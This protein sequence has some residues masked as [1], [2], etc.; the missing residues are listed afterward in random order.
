M[1]PIKAENRPLTLA[2]KLLQLII[3]LTATVT[4]GYIFYF[5]SQFISDKIWGTSIVNIG[6]SEALTNDELWAYRLSQLFYQLGTFLVSPLFF[7]FIIKKKPLVF[8]GL[9]KAFDTKKL[10]LI[11]ALLVLSIF[12]SSYLLEVLENVPW[13]QEVLNA[14]ES[15]RVLMEQLLPATGFGLVVLNVFMFVIIP[16]V[17]EE[18]YFRGMLQNVLY[19]TTENPH[20]AIFIASFLFAFVHGNMPGILAYLLMG[21]VLG[22]LFYFTNNLWYSI[23]F[24]F[25]NNGFSL[26][27]DWLYRAGKLSFDPN[28]AT[29]PS[30]IGIV[31]VALIVA[32][33]YRMNHKS[34]LPSLKVSK[35]E[36][37]AVWVKVFESSDLI[38]LQM[39]CDRLIE[40]GYDAATMNKRDSAYGFGSGEVHVPMH[41]YESALAFIKTLNI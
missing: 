6:N 4:F 11:L 12:G 29:V 1:I 24:H 18:I 16:A 35:E 5:V 38:K 2:E 31:S 17:V 34:K 36:P 19:R 40:E 10:S 22:Y 3:I 27:L 7:V 13:P 9:A 39:I 21:L 20:I 14:E 25:L 28:G 30:L 8:L 32:I 26:I 37:R 41:Q 23:L 33:L 15:G